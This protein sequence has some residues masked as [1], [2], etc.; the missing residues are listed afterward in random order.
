MT[1]GTQT[2]WSQ[3]GQMQMKKIYMALCQMTD[4]VMKTI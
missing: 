3:K 4:N 2:E 1:V